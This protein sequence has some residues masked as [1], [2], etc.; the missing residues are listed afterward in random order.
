MSC[1]R[2][3]WEPA[4]T[5]GTGGAEMTVTRDIEATRE[6]AS[7][8]AGQLCHP[9]L[10]RVE[11]VRQ[12]L[13][14]CP[15]PCRCAALIAKARRRDRN[16]SRPDWRSVVDLPPL[17]DHHRHYASLDHDH[18]TGAR[19]LRLAPLELLLGATAARQRLRGR[20][21]KRQAPATVEMAAELSGLQSAGGHSRLA[22]VPHRRPRSVARPQ[23]ERSSEL[24]NR[25][26]LKTDRSA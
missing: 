16:A 6:R 21:G 3:R 22:N 8:Q 7:L 10:A 26:P 4:C 11:D 18:G 14:P 2:V 15:P 23:S 24:P 5:G 1:E 25:T 17:R 19:G 13:R 9:L 12:G 20:A